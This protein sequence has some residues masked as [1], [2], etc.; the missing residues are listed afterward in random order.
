MEFAVTAAQGYLKA[1]KENIKR[2]S[3]ETFI[4]GTTHTRESLYRYGMRQDRTDGP[5]LDFTVEMDQ[6]I[7]RNGAAFLH[8]WACKSVNRTL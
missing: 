5:S 1:I 6:I 8:L 7:P 4:Y 2:R 3:A